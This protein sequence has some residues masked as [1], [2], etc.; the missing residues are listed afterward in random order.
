MKI[1][2]IDTVYCPKDTLITLNASVSG[3]SFSG[4]GV[5]GSKFNPSL[6]GTGIHSISYRYTNAL[7]CRS[8][9]S[10]MVRVKSNTECTKTNAFQNQKVATIKVYPN[11]NRGIIA[12]EFPENCKVLNISLYDLQGKKR[13]EKQLSH[14]DS[15]TLPVETGLYTLVLSHEKGSQNMRI[16]VE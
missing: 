15:L 13:F 4:M 14:S 2:P 7:Q 12:I 8:A 6:A 1:T 5:M 9:D 11:P 10:L 3:G 16:W